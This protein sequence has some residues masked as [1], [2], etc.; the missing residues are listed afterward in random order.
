[1]GGTA[2]SCVHDGGVSKV[3]MRRRGADSINCAENLSSVF[4]SSST[5]SSST[6]A[7]FFARSSLG[8]ASSAFLLLPSAT[9]EATRLA[10]ASSFFPL[11]PSASFRF[12]PPLPP[13]SNAPKMSSTSMASHSWHS[14]PNTK[15][16]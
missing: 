1:M 6:L 14:L 9:R 10:A 5:S 7:F 16:R 4:S 12:S 13:S 3:W 11:S 2:T 8:S 15:L